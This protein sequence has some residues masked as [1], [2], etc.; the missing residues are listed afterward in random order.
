MRRPMTRA[1]LLAAILAAA[2]ASAAG[3]QART[4]AKTLT[5]PD[6]ST[7]TVRGDTV[8]WIRRKVRDGA[9]S[10]DTMVFRFTGP[11]S[12]VRMRPAPETE[13][14]V[15]LVEHLRELVR[16]YEEDEKHPPGRPAQRPGRR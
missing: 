12:A 4:K 13:L 15:K 16:V 8:T 14:P 1:A 5:G 6:G 10:R 9:T 2:T 3:A 11:T 7:M